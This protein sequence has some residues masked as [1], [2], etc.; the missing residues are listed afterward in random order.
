MSKGALK[1][2]EVIK[3]CGVEF[4]DEEAMAAFKRAAPFM[5]PPPGLLGSDGNVRLQFGFHIEGNPGGFRS[6]FRTR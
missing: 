4:L 6:A 2:I 5:N 1:G 3:S